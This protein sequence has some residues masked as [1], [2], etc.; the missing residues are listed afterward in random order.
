M[1]YIKVILFSL[2]LGLSGCATSTSPG[3][4]DGEISQTER[5][6]L[7]LALRISTAEVIDRYSGISPDAIIDITSSVREH[8]NL[9]GEVSIEGIREILSSVRQEYGLSA[10]EMVALDEIVTLAKTR[11]EEGNVTDV[12]ARLGEYLTWIEDTALLAK[13]E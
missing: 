2:I 8:V 9:D 6:V 5:T 7:R 11:L 13:R 4:G 10:A 12:T 1:K 3:I